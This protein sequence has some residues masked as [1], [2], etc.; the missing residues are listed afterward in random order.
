[1]GWNEALRFVLELVALF[2]LGAGGWQLGRGPW[3]WVLGLGLPLLAAVLWG[4][5]RVPNDPGPAPVAIPGGVRLLLETLV[6]AGG[7]AGLL[8]AFGPWV[9]GIYVAALVIHHVAGA[10]RLRWLLGGGV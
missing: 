9:G 10:E 5:F 6:F 1:M 7:A 2:G 4:T 3:Q 8:G